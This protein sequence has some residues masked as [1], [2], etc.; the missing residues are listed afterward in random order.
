ML[1]FGWFGFNPGSSLSGLDLNIAR[2]AVTTNLAAASAG[3]V[4]TLYTMWKYGKPDASMI[5]NG[6]L[7]GLVAITAGTAFVTP[8]GAVIIGSIAGIL[9]V[10]AVGFFDRIKADDPV[11]AIAV[12]GA[13]GTFG[14]LAVGIFAENGGLIYTGSFHLLGVQALGVGAVSLWA[15]SVTTAVFYILK[16]TVGIRV[17]RDDETEGMDISEHGIAAYSAL[18]A[19]RGRSFSQLADSLSNVSVQEENIKIGHS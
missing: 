15:F 8:A 1:W 19:S 18:E 16:A 9:V 12:H 3:T 17:H 14:A 5:I 4:S 6:S 2:I 10:L 13:C 11:G 7:A